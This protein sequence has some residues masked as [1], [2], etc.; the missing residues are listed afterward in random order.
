LETTFNMLVDYEGQLAR[1]VAGELWSGLS[2][3]A[4]GAGHTKTTAFWDSL[5][6]PSEPESQEIAAR[7][8][9]MEQGL[10]EAVDALEPLRRPDALYGLVLAL[11]DTPSPLSGS[12]L[13]QGVERLKEAGV[14][15]GNIE[16][17]LLGN[18]PEE[19]ERYAGK[20]LERLRISR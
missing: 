18:R 14:R 2:R 6:S 16:P 12:L 1:R 19:C 20:L 4:L 17:A 9:V 5:R 3:A 7:I 8:F 13:Y 15:A 10:P 11:P